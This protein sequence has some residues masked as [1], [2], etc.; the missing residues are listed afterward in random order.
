MAKCGF[1]NTVSTL[2]TSMTEEQI[3]LVLKT[4]AKAVLFGDGDEAGE[5]ATLKRG[6]QLLTSGVPVYVIPT[7]T[8]EDPD[9]LGRQDPKALEVA[10]AFTTSFPRFRL[11]KA[12]NEDPQARLH[13]ITQ[14][15]EELSGAP[16]PVQETLLLEAGE[17]LHLKITLT[18]KKNKPAPIRPK[19]IE[20][21][22]P[23]IEQEILW[24]ISLYEERPETILL[25]WN[26]IGQ[27][28]GLSGRGR[29]L[30]RSLMGAFQGEGVTF[31]PED[32]E[33]L[34][35]IFQRF[36]AVKDSWDWDNFIEKAT[37]WLKES[38][39][40]IEVERSREQVTDL[41]SLTSYIEQVII[42]QGARS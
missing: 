17:I 34:T 7:P 40:R 19:R 35:M 26:A 5:V 33:E 14:F 22:L 36:Q 25:L 31:Q 3:E 42:H 12:I 37:S 27:G 1:P 23:R 9:S 6:V 18:P 28:H 29:T 38:H 13:A 8:G 15:Q 30:A 10:V 21:K 11:S 2:G 20:A 32:K 4:G 24:A 41:S 39:L 16:K